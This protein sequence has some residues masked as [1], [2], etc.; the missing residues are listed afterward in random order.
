MLGAHLNGNTH[1]L[2]QRRSMAELQRYE[3]TVEAAVNCGTG[4]VISEPQ[5]TRK[6]Y[7]FHCPCTEGCATTLPPQ[8]YDEGVLSGWPYMGCTAVTCSP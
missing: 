8:R 6:Q 1:W 2:M 3:R 4:G 7:S 5:Q